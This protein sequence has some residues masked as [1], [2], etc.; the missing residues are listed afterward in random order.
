MSTTLLTLIT[1]YN[2]YLDEQTQVDILRFGFGSANLTI[3]LVVDINTL[4]EY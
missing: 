1:F 2:I 3:V 4:Q